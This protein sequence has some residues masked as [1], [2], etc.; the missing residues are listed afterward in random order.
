VLA[1]RLGELKRIFAD[2]DPTVIFARMMDFFNQKPEL[3]NLASTLRSF[4]EGQFGIALS[5]V[6][7]FKNLTDPN[8]LERSSMPL[9][10]TSSAKMASSRLTRY[11][12][13]R[14]CSWVAT[15]S[16]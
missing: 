2:D 6:T 14:Q 5:M 8:F 9:F 16:N 4:L 3:A 1:D 15:R 13:R 12:S 10:S 11:M 7:T